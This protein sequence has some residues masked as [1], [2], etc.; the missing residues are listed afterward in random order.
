MNFQNFKTRFMYT[1]AAIL[2]TL[3]FLFTLILLLLGR[4]SAAL[5]NLGL[6]TFFCFLYI[7]YWNKLHPEKIITLPYKHVFRNVGWG[8]FVIGIFIGIFTP[9]Q[10]S[11]KNAAAKAKTDSA[12]P[13]PSADPIPACDGTSITS[14]C[15]VDGV[16]YSKYIYHP[17]VP[18][19]SHTETVSTYEDQLIGYFTKCGDGSWSPSNSKGKGACSGHGGVSDY[20]APKYGSVKVDKEQTVIDPAQDEWYET[21]V[22]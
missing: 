13:E 6:T 16:I 7:K 20:N 2:M 5:I 14:D 12:T 9:N 10:K 18:E 4:S 3:S 17:A 22:K 1:A 19:T 21:E 11:A 8:F 15:Q